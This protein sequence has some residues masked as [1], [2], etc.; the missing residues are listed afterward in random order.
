M[1]WLR[2]QRD[3]AGSR[4]LDGR[5]AAWARCLHGGRFGSQLRGGTPPHFNGKAV[6]YPRRFDANATITI[7]APIPTSHGHV[8]DLRSTIGMGVFSAGVLVGC[9]AVGAMDGAGVEGTGV[10]AGAGVALVP[11]TFGRRSTIGIGVAAVLSVW[12]RTTSA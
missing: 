2:R 1:A 4:W 5:L 12:V 7:K 6:T 10:A 8:G 9:K 11:V 3:R